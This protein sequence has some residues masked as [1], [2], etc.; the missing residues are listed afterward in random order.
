MLVPVL[1]AVVAVVLPAAEPEDAV[2]LVVLQPAGG[3]DGE[4]ELGA[5]GGRDGGVLQG[6]QPEDY[7]AVLD[8]E[9][10]G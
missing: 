5:E 6:A 10:E 1:P 4:G 2:G 3:A 9:V 7:A 8:A